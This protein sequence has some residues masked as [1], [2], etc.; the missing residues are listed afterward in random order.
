MPLPRHLA[1]PLHERKQ[2]SRGVGMEVPHLPFGVMVISPIPFEVSPSDLELLQ[3]LFSFSQPSSRTGLFISMVS[4][5]VHTATRGSYAR[6]MGG[7]DAILCGLE[8]GHWGRIGEDL[9]ECRLGRDGGRS[10][11]EVMGIRRIGGIESEHGGVS[12]GWR[13]GNARDSKKDGPA[14][15]YFPNLF[16]RWTVELEQQ[17]RRTGRRLSA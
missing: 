9:S 11:I 4:R 2:F 7:V 14:P 3:R 16:L 10:G 1:K 5:A 17:S 8:A 6:A 13:R 15:G 12:D